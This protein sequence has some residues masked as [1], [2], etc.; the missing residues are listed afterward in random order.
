VR[1]LADDYV[2][3]RGPDGS[4]VAAPDQCPHRQSPLSAGTI[5]SGCLRCPYHGWLLVLQGFV[6]KFPRRQPV[7]RYPLELTW[8]QFMPRNSTA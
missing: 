4:V 8:R 6:K 5:E 3:W 1:L 2:L 7:F